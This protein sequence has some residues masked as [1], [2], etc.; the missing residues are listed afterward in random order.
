MKKKR[1]GKRKVGFWA[2]KFTDPASWKQ[3]SQSS[4]KQNRAY[5]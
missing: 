4:K 1:L 2:G 3:G 5:N